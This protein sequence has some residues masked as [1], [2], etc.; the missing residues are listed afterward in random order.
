MQK[1]TIELNNSEQSSD[2]ARVGFLENATFVLLL[3]I[4][5]IVPVFFVP[6][7]LIPFQFSKVLLLSV[8]ILVAFGFWIIARLKDGHFVF[9]KTSFL[10]TAAGVLLVTLLSALFS[11]VAKDAFLGQALEV[12]T[13]GSSAILFLLLFL[14]PFVFKSKDRIFYSYIVFFAAFFLIAAFQ[15]FRLIFG[16]DFLSLGIFTDITSNTVGKWNDLDVFFGIG[17]VLSLITLELISLSK[18]FKILAYAALIVSLFFLAIVNFTPVWYVIAFFSLIF[19]VYVISFDKSEA[20]LEL[21][22]GDSGAEPIPSLRKIPV[23]SLTVLLISLVFILGGNTIGGAIS[24]K[25]SI[26]QVEARPSWGATFAVAKSVLVKDPFLGAGPNRFTENWLLYK[27]EGINST[28]F[29]NTDFNFGIGFIPTFLVTTGLLGAISWV[30]FLGFFLYLGF[31]AI[32][33]V[34]GDKVSRYLVTSSFL[35]SL[36]LW[37]ISIFYIP[38]LTIVTLTFFFTGLFI[39]SLYQSGAVKEKVISFIEDPR[40]GFVSVLVLI[41]LLIGTIAVGYSFVEKFIAA[42]YFQKGVVT[43]NTEGNV[44]K[45][46]K[47]LQKAIELDNDSSYYRS[48]VQIDMMRLSTLLSQNS[49]TI[50]ED[51]LRTQFQGL[52]SSALG[53]A[54]QAVLFG[55]TDYQN[56]LSL[57]QVYEAIVPLK[58]PNVSA[59][60]SA[61]GA[62]QQAIALNPKSPAIL[63]TLGRLEAAHADNAKAKD[64]IGQALRQKNNYTDAI[65]LLAQIQVQE[66]NIKDAIDSVS[67]ASYLAPNDSGIFFQLGLLRYNDKNYQGAVDAFKKATDL[68][69]AYANAKYFLGLSYQKT[70]KVNEAIKEFNDL[71]TLNPDNKEI[72][73]ILANLT[74]GRDP[75]ANAAPPI[76]NKPEKRSALPVQEKG[77]SEKSKTGET[78][79]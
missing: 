38:S 76:D 30:L 32:L 52:F 69:P 27:P 44:D 39:A 77:T 79:R 21:S 8:V 57:G 3:A 5:F 22:Q 24:E 19:L 59:Y 71:K 61:L 4:P 31:R 29:W 26:A 28:I 23:T 65:F 1:V 14:V 53:H 18:L 66:G 42:V 10:L 33:S 62:Y 74:A 63:L 68:N 40:K 67:A 35:V 49:K 72:E 17:T 60:E 56:W 58:I 46:E 6:S 34:I 12:G 7:I 16:T 11:G 48:L 2:R 36:F 13:A 20:S 75:F 41:L 37:I 15:I 55:N 54:E 43:F 70:A 64:Y 50:S 51:T 47:Y 73:L 78:T 25:L 45:A 9:P